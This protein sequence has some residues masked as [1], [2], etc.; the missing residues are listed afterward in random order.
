MKVKA[1][2]SVRNATGP[3][4]AAER[5]LLVPHEGRNAAAPSVAELLLHPREVRQ[6]EVTLEQTQGTFHQNKSFPDMN[7]SHLKEI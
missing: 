6:Q 1:Q 2:T 5:P 4:G 3:A 7:S